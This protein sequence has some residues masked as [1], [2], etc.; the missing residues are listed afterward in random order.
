M[1]KQYANLTG[2]PVSFDITSADKTFGRKT[3]SLLS[4]RTRRANRRNTRAL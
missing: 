3:T 2:Q 1:S 4:R